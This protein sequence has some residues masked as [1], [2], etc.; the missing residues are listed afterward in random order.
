MATDAH[1]T[2][3]TDDPTWV[4]SVVFW[5]TLFLAIAIYAAI[6]LAPKFQ[7]YLVL[8]RDHTIGQWN[9]VSL[10]KQVQQLDRVA[11]ALEEDPQFAAELARSRFGAI[12]PAQSAISIADDLQINSAVMSVKTEV[13]LPWYFGLVNQFASNTWL[14]YGGLTV[15][16]LLIVFGFGFLHPHYSGIVRSTL[17]RLGA[18]L[19]RIGHRYQA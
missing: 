7:R 4:V 3:S 14:R 12:D 11:T 16:S 17:N 13:D 9:L 19:A 5:L 10:E 2:E 6:A 8:Q 18:G 15:S 1:T